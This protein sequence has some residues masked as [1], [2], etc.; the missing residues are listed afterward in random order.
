MKK[1]VIPIVLYDGTTVVKGANFKNERTIGSIEAIANLY[2]RRRP[3]EIFFLDVQAT[4]QGRKPNFEAFEYFSSKFD[5]PFAVGGGIS[6]VEDATRCIAN[7]AEKVVLGTAVHSNPR[8]IQEIASKLGS[9]A[10]VVSVDFWD[11]QNCIYQNCGRNLINQSVD[12]FVRKVQ[13]SGAGELLVQDIS[14]DGKMKGL[15]L[16][17]LKSLIEITDVPIVVAGGAGLPEHFLDAFE[18]G[19]SGVAAGAIFQFTRFTPHQISVY[20]RE[21][22]VDVRT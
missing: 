20:L 14:R 15:N 18:I 3:D 12:D 9:Q 17:R 4:N 13:E 6:S 8:L 11:D 1:R 10:I 5:I 16:A 19:A 22:G 7:G 2:A 21:H